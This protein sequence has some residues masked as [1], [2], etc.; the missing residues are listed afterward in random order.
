LTESSGHFWLVSDEYDEFV[1][2]EI[3]SGPDPKGRLVNKGAN[4]SI[5]V[6]TWGEILD[7]NNA[8]LQFIKEKLEHR[9]DEGQA[10]A[11]LEEKHREFLEGVIV[12]DERD[13]G[14]DD[15]AAA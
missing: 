11:H 8:R 14:R 13:S 6:M 15:V 4:V 10:L 3:E 1:A 12:R 7:E 5:G 9:A 2:S